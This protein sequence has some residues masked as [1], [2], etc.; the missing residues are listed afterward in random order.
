MQKRLIYS[1]TSASNMTPLWIF[2][3]YVLTSIV[4]DACGAVAGL[5]VPSQNGPQGRIVLMR[6]SMWMCDVHTPYI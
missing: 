5:F 3:L 1:A 2:E 6:P 4:C